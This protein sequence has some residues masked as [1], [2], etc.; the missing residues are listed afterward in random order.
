MINRYTFYRNDSVNDVLLNKEFDFFYYKPSI[1]RMK[2]HKGI[3]KR[4]YFLYL[5]W[6]LFTFGSYRILY[7]K[8]KNTGDIAHFSNIIPRFFKYNFMEHSDLQIAHCFTYKKYRGRGLYSFAL[9][10]INHTFNDKKIWIGSHHSNIESIKVIE[11]LGFRK[12]FD[13]TKRTVLGI[14][15]KIDE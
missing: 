2:L 12:M 4:S 15:Y 6:Y 13:V 8:L 9:S 10:T 14:Y 11:K 1:F 7:I 3:Y 5:F